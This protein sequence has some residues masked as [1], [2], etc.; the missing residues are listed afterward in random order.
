MK[1]SQMVNDAELESNTSIENNDVPT[2]QGNDND[3]TNQDNETLADDLQ[4]EIDA[5]KALIS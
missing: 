3:I 1:L 2:L 5:I 4:A